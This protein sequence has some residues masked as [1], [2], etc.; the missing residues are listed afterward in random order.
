MKHMDIT[1]VST[2]L[3][4][5]LSVIGVL[6]AIT[7]IIVEVVKKVTWDKIPTQLLA[8]LVAEV[9]TLVAFFAYAQIKGRRPLVHGGGRNRRRL[10]RGL[11]RHVRLREAEGDPCLRDQERRITTGRAHPGHS[12]QEV[13]S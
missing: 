1:S 5:L 12:T 9:L 4:T 10:P 13:Q 7:N 11:R 2:T 6:V 3:A 8:L